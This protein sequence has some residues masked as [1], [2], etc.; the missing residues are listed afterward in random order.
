[1]DI[2]RIA[3]A[4]QQPWAWLLV[5]GFKDVEN[6]TWPLP[7][8]YVGR[9]ILIQAS[10]RPTFNLSMARDILEEIHARYG[11]PGGLRFPDEGRQ[12]GGIVGVVRFV[13]CDQGHRTSPWAESGQWHWRVAD[14]APLPF[15]PCK[16]RLGFFRVDYAAP[17][18]RPNL[19]GVAS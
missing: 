5:N 3:I 6:R 4:V 15:M 10:A 9:R 11:L 18:T 17:E 7:S 16:G 2:P 14:A 13:G 12:S 19:L 8:A 1:M